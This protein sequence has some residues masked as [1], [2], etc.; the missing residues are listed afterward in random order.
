[1]ISAYQSAGFRREVNSQLK[2]GFGANR[3][4]IARGFVEDA[5]AIIKENLKVGLEQSGT[6]E[7]FGIHAGGA[8]YSYYFDDLAESTKKKKRGRIGENK[9]W[10]DWG[11][12]HP[13]VSL[14]DAMNA[15]HTPKVT[16]ST[17]LVG[18][19]LRKGPDRIDFEINIEIKKM[20]SPLDDLVRRPLMTG[21]V[22]EAY[23]TGD[24]GKLN[25]LAF[26]DFGTKSGRGKSKGMPARPWINEM[27]ATIGNLM[28]EELIT[29]K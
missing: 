22:S 9:F 10:L 24:N 23:S 5:I 19:D 6:V 15:V 2:N 29:N 26:L 1:M 3:A 12:D 13:R 4:N 17:R 18:L 7:S 11:G 16:H 8:S 21:E 20:I 28:F 25:V 27:S 14:M